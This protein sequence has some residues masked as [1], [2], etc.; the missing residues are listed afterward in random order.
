MTMDFCAICIHSEWVDGVPCCSNTG[1][2]EPVD[3]VEDCDIWQIQD[4]V[5]QFRAKR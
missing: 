3:M 1:T 5:E 2:Y 4:K